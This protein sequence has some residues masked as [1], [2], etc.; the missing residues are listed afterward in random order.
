MIAFAELVLIYFIINLI[1]VKAGLLKNLLKPLGLHSRS[2]LPVPWSNATVI[3]DC[4]YSELNPG[5]L[6]TVIRDCAHIRVQM[7][8]HVEVKLPQLRGQI[9][10]FLQYLSLSHS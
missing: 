10:R 5:L 3:R 4:C 9:D 1:F 8:V 6:L 7:K 2:N